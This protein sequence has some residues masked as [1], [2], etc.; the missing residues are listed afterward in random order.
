MD[1]R[2]LLTFRV[3]AHERSF[4]RAA[5]QLSR[6][7]P[8]VSSQIALLETEI[9]VRLFDRARRGLRLTPAGDVLLEHADHV[10]WR[11]ALADEQLAALAGAHRGQVRLGSFPTAMAGLVASGIA[12]LRAAGGDIRVLVDE[13]TSETLEPRLLGGDFDIALGY[14]DRARPRREIEGAE[15]VDLVE[16]TF[17]VGLPV[18]HPLAERTGTLELAELAGEDWIMASPRGFL[19]DACREAGFEPHIVALCHEPVGTHGMIRRG[20]GIGFVPSLLVHEHPDIVMRPVAGPLPRRQIYAMLP[21][22]ERHPHARH[23]LTALREAADDFAPR[24]T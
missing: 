7:Q 4:S 2:R 13:V 14:Q 18:E 21:P 15:R 16:E 1:P 6:S 12:R 5:E 10:A 9:G 24:G 19:S 22:G 8:S 11:L 3:V 20:L 17:L 23:V